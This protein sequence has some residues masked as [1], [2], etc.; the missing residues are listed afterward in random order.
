MRHRLRHLVL[1][2]MRYPAACGLV[3]LLIYI[4]CQASFVISS[5]NGRPA[6]DAFYSTAASVGATLLV[7]DVIAAAT[8][9][10]RVIF[11]LRAPFWRVYW[12]GMVA[13]ATLSAAVVTLG[14]ILVLADCTTA[15]GQTTCGS[16]A[17]VSLV[18]PSLFFS[19]GL[20]LLQ[21]VVALTRRVQLGF[22]IVDS[23]VSSRVDAP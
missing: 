14:S 18:F 23:N 9:G 16:G 10:P 19:L 2:S 5:S 15:H 6:S 21:V 13:F 22:A 11:V 17:T 3:P 1:R 4:G 20:L 12:I 8:L 7:A